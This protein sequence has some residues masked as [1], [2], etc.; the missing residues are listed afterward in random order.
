M[1]SEILLKPQTGSSCFISVCLLIL[2]LASVAS[3]GSAVGWW[4]FGGTG[5]TIV[6][7][8][9]PGVH[10]A[11]LRNVTI[12]TAKPYVT[13]AFDGTSLER[14]TAF[15]D[16]SGMKDPLTRL[17]DHEPTTALRFPSASPAANK[18]AA[19]F[20]PYSTDL[21][22]TNLTL[23]A[24][25][26]IPTDAV[27]RTDA[28]LPIAMNGRALRKGFLFG[29]KIDST[30]KRG[31]P[32]LNY[33][34]L[35]NG[36]VS[37]Y[38]WA[39]DPSV[40]PTLIDGKWHHVAL[41]VTEGKRYRFYVDYAQLDTRGSSYDLA[42]LNAEYPDEDGLFIG[43][44][45]Y[46]KG[47]TFYGDIAE[48]R[49]SDQ[50]LDVGEFLRPLPP[51]P[52]DGD[53]KVW[54]P[55]D[56]ASWFGRELQPNVTNAVRYG[57]FN[58]ADTFGYKPTWLF[59]AAANHP[60]Y[61]AAG[62]ET[63]VDT[64]RGGRFAEAAVPDL[65]SIRLSSTE[66]S[67]HRAH[68]IS[69]DDPNNDTAKGSF[70][71][72]AWFKPDRDGAAYDNDG[73]VLIRSSFCRIT[74]F[75]E[76]GKVMFRGY[77]GANGTEEV[78]ATSAERVDDGAWHHVAMV[79]SREATNVCFYLDDKL[80]GSRNAKLYDGVPCYSFTLGSAE[81]SAFAFSGW[82]DGVRLTARALRPWEFL[83]GADYAG[84]R[85][86]LA[87]ARFEH[88]LTLNSLPPT[89]AEGAFAARSGYPLPDYSSSVCG[90]RLMPDRSDAERTLANSASMDIRNGVAYWTVP[91]ESPINKTDITVEFVA[92]FWHADAVANLV[93]LMAND[94][95]NIAIWRM[96]V[97][98]P[99]AGFGSAVKFP[100]RTVAKDGTVTLNEPKW[101]MAENFFD[102]R[103]A[104][105]AVWI[106]DV[107]D[108]QGPSTRVTLFCDYVQVGQPYV[109]KGTLAAP[110]NPTGVWTGPNCGKTVLAVHGVSAAGTELRGRVDELRITNGKLDPSQFM[111]LT[112]K[113]G[114]MLIMR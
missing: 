54:L 61:P 21:H 27:N 67:P 81:A 105:W 37:S 65:G 48:V 32:Y 104:H 25:I 100:F 93:G 83:T 71:L 3:D 97:G 43:A 63:A 90:L 56:S 70:T 47:R 99:T 87:Q 7:V 19:A 46:Q 89:I 69:I 82:L 11:K 103:W 42:Y 75:T 6:N 44:N 41:T 101:E 24:F 68:R 62:A 76:T 8:A 108:A 14:A 77:Q 51:G 79:Y 34:Y 53:T 88:S 55:F 107:P 31:V 94:W 15:P 102:G 35:N 96:Y 113:R 114:S 58:G 73:M 110:G 111:Q 22:L 26:R 40:C 59:D 23:E 85:A 95:N 38:E 5:D 18:T 16:G 92:R 10:D 20:V 12:T 98:I 86:T 64:V 28:F 74:Y 29:V 33:M 66:N 9:S 72:E 45:V 106:E 1:V 60:R 2:P 112:Q 49:L 78:S 91:N 52:I 84:E 17:L 36:K 80:V 4:R 13:N 50:R 57:L 109:A 39:S 30:T